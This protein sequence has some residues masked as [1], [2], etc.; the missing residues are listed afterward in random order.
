MGKR[1]V[2]L[3]LATLY[4]VGAHA[5]PL[6]AAGFELLRQV[7]PVGDNSAIVYRFAPDQRSCSVFVQSTQPGHLSAL[8]ESW[9]TKEKPRVPFQ[10]G[11]LDLIRYEMS[12]PHDAAKEDTWIVLENKALE[13]WTKSPTPKPYWRLRLEFSDADQFRRETLKSVYIGNMSFPVAHVMETGMRC[14]L[15]KTADF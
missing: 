10:N 4:A 8:V 6:A 9:N 15:A 1:F 11:P 7:F 14:D 5:N 3:M 12:I 13:V 2:S